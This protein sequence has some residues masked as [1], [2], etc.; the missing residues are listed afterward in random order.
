[1]GVAKL[2]NEGDSSRCPRATCEQGAGSAQTDEK[3]I[4]KSGTGGWL[5]VNRLNVYRDH[6]E[7]TRGE[8]FFFVP[9]LTLGER[10]KIY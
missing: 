6:S 8:Y 1:M 5:I 2:S 3:T 4:K 7:I 9:R 10:E